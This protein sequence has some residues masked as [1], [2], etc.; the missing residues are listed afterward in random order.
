MGMLRILSKDDLQKIHNASLQ[1]LRDTG[2]VIHHGRSLDGLAEAGASV[3]HQKHKVL[4][5]PEL[6]D[7]CL[8]RT[9]KF[10]TL[11]GRDSRRDLKI[12]AGKTYTRSASG[13]IYIIDSET[14][15]RRE[16]SSID[17]RNFTRAQDALENIS[18]CGGSPYPFDTH[19]AMRDIYQIRIMLENT[20]KH[21]RFQPLSAKGLDCVVEL[22]RAVVGT[23]DE[24]KKR[25]IVSCVTA[26]VSPL[27]YSREQT[28]IIMRSGALG[29]PVMLGS[30]PT[31]GAT[32]PVTL[33]GSLALENAE[34][35]AGIVLAQVMNPRSP[36]SYGPRMPSMDMRTGLSAWGTIEFGLAAAAGAQL[37]QF[38]GI[39]TDL[40]GA[41]S[42]AKVLDEQAAIERT[43]NA[44]LPALAGANVVNGAG[45]LESILTV[46][47]EQLVID[48]EMFGMLF[49]L[50]RGVVLDEE[51]LALD[52][53][54][55]VG[56]GGNFLTDTH[57]KQ[58][59]V[60]E[61]FLPQV[62]DRKPREVWEQ[63][64][65]RDVVAASREI[66]TKITREHEPTPLD[67]DVVKEMDYILRDA[68]K[69]FTQN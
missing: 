33:A 10:H 36:L 68:K 22:A 63:A 57:T 9:P 64:G 61:H 19:P 12:E 69:H 18:F 45:V 48:S 8:R 53:I 51:K 17:A 13:S 43:F 27:V 29:L 50:L 24:L 31:V 11:A 6:V 32:G 49:R 59:Y 28:E 52:V 42:D 67:K 56:P 21:I 7:E 39:E 40:Y 15:S 47:L 20:E 54:N 60:M 16:A 14:G 37:G 4:I 2:I 1:I 26:P 38:Y 58:H 55:R 34:I 5:S 23:K 46:S 66:V 25:P 3:D 41:T 44:V 35:L 62:F 65:G 30:T